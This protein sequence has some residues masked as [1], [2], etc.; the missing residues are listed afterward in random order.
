MASV[1]NT[2]LVIPVG[3]ALPLVATF[4]FPIVKPDLYR[5][6]FGSMKGSAILIVTSLIGALAFGFYGF[7]ET[8]PLISGTYLGANLYLAY[9]VLLVL[10]V[11]A[12]VIY[13]LGRY[14]MRKL[15]IDPKA[16][17]SEL[18]PE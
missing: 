14:S 5:R 17:F 7:A 8:S 16:L 9:E 15:G 2:S 3:F 10:L 18:P 4:L 1:L 11:I 6:L 13:L 12:V